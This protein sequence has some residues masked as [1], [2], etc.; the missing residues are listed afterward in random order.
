MELFVEG[1]SSEAPINTVIEGSVRLPMPF[2]FEKTGF[3]QHP[4]S[5]AYWHFA[6]SNKRNLANKRCSV[7]E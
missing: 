5:Q 6:D 4:L 2:F 1:R 3:D 7:I